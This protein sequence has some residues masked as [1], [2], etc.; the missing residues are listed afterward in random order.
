M[1]PFSCT[2]LIVSCNRLNSRLKHSNLVYM[3][4][5]DIGRLNERSFAQKNF[6]IINNVD[7]PK[8]GLPSQSPQVRQSIGLALETSAFLCATE[9]N[10]HLLINS[11]DNYQISLYFQ[12][13]PS[14]E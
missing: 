7:K 12:V 8:A 2:N 10:L 4:Y 14:F 3:K 9:A 5:L 1:T 13:F 6:V 11:I